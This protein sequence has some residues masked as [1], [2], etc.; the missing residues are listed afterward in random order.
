MSVTWYGEL[1]KR[2]ESAKLRQVFRERKE[3]NTEAKC[4]NILS[5][6]RNRGVIP[7]AD[8]G[9]VGNKHS[10]DIERYSVVHIDDIVMNS[11]NVIIGSVGRSD[12]YGVLSPVYY[13]LYVMNT[14]RNNVMYLDYVFQTTILQRELTKHGNGILAHRMRIPMDKLKSVELP[15][16]PRDEQDQ[17]VRYLE[18]KVSQI[19]KL[20]NA[21]RRQITLLQEQKQAIIDQTVTKGVNPDATMRNSEITWLGEIPETWCVVRF[22]QC[23][24]AIEQGWSPAASEDVVDDRHWK[25]LTLSSI[26]KGEFFSDAVKPIDINAS[27]PTKLEVHDGDFLLTR[28]NTRD[29]VGDICIAKNVQPKTIICDL[30]YRLQL[31]ET[32]ITPCFAAYFLLSSYGRMQI[33]QDARGSSGTMPKLAHKHIR[34]WNIT[35]PSIPE[36]NIIAKFIDKQVEPIKRAMHAIQ[37]QIVFLDEYCTRLISDVVTGKLDIRGVVVPEYEAVED[38]GA[39]ETT[40]TEEG[41]EDE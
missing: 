37:G 20:I 33:Q 15:I 21:K 41:V 32:M 31:A 35:L 5:V 2:W 27:V 24:N 18:W 11:M 36:Q 40:H 3:K 25:V 19:N 13:V 9:N 12:Y 7:Y 10:E 8:K 17:I 30:I 38:V 26:K 22:G 28:S 14:E 39:D 23:I 4:S 1:P 16:P 34:S 29:L 6:M